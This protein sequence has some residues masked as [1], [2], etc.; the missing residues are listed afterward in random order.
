MKY[1]DKKTLISEEKVLFD[2]NNLPSVSILATLAN[3]DSGWK[4]DTGRP[5]PYD[6]YVEHFCD[7]SKTLTDV[8]KC[9]KENT[10]EL[11]E[12]IDNHSSL[13]N[14]KYWTLDIS[15]F[16]LG[17]IFTLNTTF[18]LGSEFSHSLTL[19]LNKSLHYHILIND[20]KFFI[21]TANPKTMP[22]I[23][24]SM[25]DDESAFVY[26]DAVYHKILDRPGQ[27]CEASE[28]YNFTI[29]VKTSL[30]TKIGCRLEWDV[31]SSLEIPVCTEVE[32]LLRFEKE[33]FKL[34]NMDQAT[35]VEYT[36]CNIPCT[37]T[38][39]KLATAPIKYAAGERIIQILLSSSQVS[40]KTE[41]IIYP[42]ESFVSEFGGALGLFLGFSFLM[43]WDVIKIVIRTWVTKD[44]K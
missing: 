40:S 17:K 15:T 35:V 41:E 11:N 36:G 42:F 19:D 20:P 22:H 7:V 29:C 6:A 4:L 2:S 5:I 23:L 12:M 33:Y 32:Q 34:M 13:A 3:I 39:Y 10:F 43:I 14:P 31:W 24:L 18:E 37:Y 25:N 44:R 9:I 28:S 26:I 1:Q 16:H 30:S 38:E 21:S 8:V 27:H